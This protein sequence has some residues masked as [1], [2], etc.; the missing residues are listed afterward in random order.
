MASLREQILEAL[1]DMLS[2]ALPVGTG[3]ERNQDKPERLTAGNLV[4]LRDGEPGEPEI[5]LSPL[6]YNFAHRIPLEIAAYADDPAERYE[7][8]D[9]LLRPIGAAV[10][11]DRTLGG[12]CDFLEVEAPDTGD[13]ETDGAEPFRWADVVIVAHYATTDPLN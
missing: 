6:T 10:A 11:A 3:V 2:A 4:I 8:L 12:L 5:D 13:A 1:K 7:A 9:A